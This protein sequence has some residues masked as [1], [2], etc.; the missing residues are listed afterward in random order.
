MKIYN[1]DLAESALHKCTLHDRAKVN[2]HEPQIQQQLPQWLLPDNCRSTSHLNS[3]VDRD[4]VAVTTTGPQNVIGMKYRDVLWDMI[5]QLAYSQTETG[6]RG[7]WRYRVDIANYG[8]SDNSIVQWTSI[9]LAAAEGPPW[10]L[11]APS[12]VKNE[13]GRW[14]AYSQCG[15][16]GFGYTGS[17]PANIA[18]TGSGIYTHFYLDP[19]TTT[20]EPPVEAALNYLCNNWFSTSA[21]GHFNGGFYGMYAVKKALED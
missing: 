4:T 18:R 6:G 3:G 7:G 2:A 20:I 12:F 9:A 13:L 8:S 21:W 14:I 5:D 16:G 17:C 11:N 19:D 10:F 15:D 1:Q